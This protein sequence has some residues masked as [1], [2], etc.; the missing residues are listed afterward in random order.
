M[1]I[2][3]L[4]T[5]LL[6]IGGCDIFNARDAEP[7][8]QP[9]SNFQSAVTPELLIENLKNSLKDKNIENYLACFADTS[10]TDKKFQ[11]SPSS[12]ALSQFPF[13]SDNWGKKNEE[14]YFN[15]M[16]TKIDQNLPITLTLSNPV[17]T[18]QGDSLFY[19]ASYFLNVPH[20]DPSIPTSFEGELKF[21]M[22]RDSR[23]VWIIYY[24]QDIR[25]G[26]TASW[27]ELKGRFY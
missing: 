27:S 12:G 8:D 2:I 10:F 4:L 25:S 26:N 22:V 20:N 9:R 16:K 17:T 1:R 5:I 15:N 3:F 7:P 19:T 11:F 13:L 6:F 18:P 23:S 21:D 24:W 14:Q